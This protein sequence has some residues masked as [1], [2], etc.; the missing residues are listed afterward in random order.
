[1]TRRPSQFDGVPDSRWD[2]AVQRLH[3]V[4]DGSD[5]DELL[6][7]SWLVHG[8]LTWL[9]R[10]E[11]VMVDTRH[12]SG[13]VLLEA[14][15]FNAAVRLRICGTPADRARQDDKFQSLLTRVM[16]GATPQP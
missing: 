7:L 15:R 14:H 13:R 2:R 9:R 11:E 12:L 8:R 16:T 5:L 3:N 1:M 10:Q 4:V 6:V